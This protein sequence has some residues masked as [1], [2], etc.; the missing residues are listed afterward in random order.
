M[1]TFKYQRANHSNCSNG[2]GLWEIDGDIS[3]FLSTYESFRPSNIKYTKNQTLCSRE[4]VHFESP[5]LGYLIFG[6]VVIDDCSD[7]LTLFVKAPPQLQIG[8]FILPHLFSSIHPDTSTINRSKLAYDDGVTHVATWG[9][10]TNNATLKT[11]HPAEELSS[12]FWLYGRVSCE[13][14]SSFHVLVYAKFN[15][16]SCMVPGFRFWRGPIRALLLYSVSCTS[17]TTKL[18]QY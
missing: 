18:L 15:G 2:D 7:E 17:L 1:V 5:I 9:H 8:W 16:L 3:L 14:K 6:G 12:F 10:P 13:V 4:T 11:A